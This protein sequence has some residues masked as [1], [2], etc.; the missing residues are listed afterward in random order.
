[1]ASSTDLKILWE[2]CQKEG[3]PHSISIVQYCQMNGIVYN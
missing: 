2:R 1:M 3:V